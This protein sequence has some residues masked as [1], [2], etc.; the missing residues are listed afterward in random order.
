MAYRNTRNHSKTPKS[1]PH[2][3]LDWREE[4]WKFTNFSW[5][6][7][8]PVKKRNAERKYR[9]ALE[10]CGYKM[11]VGTL[12]QTVYIKGPSQGVWN[13]VESL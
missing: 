11:T 10:R 2:S 9:E 8:S 7:R 5:D 12:E 1:K 4:R 13:K 6:L 3:D